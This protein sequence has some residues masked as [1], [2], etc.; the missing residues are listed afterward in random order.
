MAEDEELDRPPRLK[1][2]GAAT[3]DEVE[4]IARMNTLFKTFGVDVYLWFNGGREQRPAKPFFLSWTKNDG[5]LHKKFFARID[6]AEKA[7][8]ALIGKLDP[9]D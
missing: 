6:D 5:H 2:G 7:G 9:I 1:K 4:R 3:K 8:H